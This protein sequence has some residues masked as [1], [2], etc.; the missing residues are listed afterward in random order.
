MKEVIIA[1]VAAV[2]GAIGAYCAA[3]TPTEPRM[4]TICYYESF[5]GT[6]GCREI[7][8]PIDP[9]ETVLTPLHENEQAC[10]GGG[11]AIGGGPVTTYDGAFCEVDAAGSVRAITHWCGATKPKRGTFESDGDSVACHTDG[12]QTT[13]CAR[14]RPVDSALHPCE[15]SVTRNSEVD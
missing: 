14:D 10:S 7:A 13:I 1:I 9:K 3:R 8:L 6:N 15:R 4:A 12:R 2:I 5:A 11:E